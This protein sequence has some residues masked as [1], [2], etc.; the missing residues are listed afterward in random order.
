MKRPMMAAILSIQGNEIVPG[1]GTTAQK[2]EA[3]LPIDSQTLCQAINQQLGILS[4]NGLGVYTKSTDVN[5]HFKGTYQNGIWLITSGFPSPPPLMGCL[6]EG[7]PTL[8]VRNQSYEAP[9]NAAYFFYVVL[10]IR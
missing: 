3:A 8:G 5:G 2:L 1:L 9:V 4:Y 7:E 6:S 10:L